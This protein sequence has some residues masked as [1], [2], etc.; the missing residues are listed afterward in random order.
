[1]CTICRNPAS[2]PRRQPRLATRRDHP[3]QRDHHE[4]TTNVGFTVTNTLVE[5]PGGFTVDKTVVDPDSVVDPT[6]VY[7]GTFS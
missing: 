6:T 3:G 5:L 1:M 7:A 4:P 2:S